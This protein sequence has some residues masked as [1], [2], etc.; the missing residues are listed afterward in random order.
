VKIKK[1]DKRYTHFLIAG[2][3]IRTVIVFSIL[4]YIHINPRHI[5]GIYKWD[6]MFEIFGGDAGLFEGIV[7]HHAR[8]VSRGD[9]FSGEPL[10]MQDGIVY[11]IGPDGE[12]N[13]CSIIYDPT[14][15]TGS[16]GDIIKPVGRY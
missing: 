12:D 2:Y 3:L 10:K 1:R 15:G 11:S 16:P 9:P 8:S 6:K 5:P 4:G 14:N 13:F 7:R